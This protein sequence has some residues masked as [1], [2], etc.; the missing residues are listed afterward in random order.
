MLTA[1]WRINELLAAV[2]SVG[3]AFDSLLEW[4]QSAFLKGSNK[5]WSAAT[6]FRHVA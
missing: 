5:P 3:D 1:V 4:E 6:Y 2:E